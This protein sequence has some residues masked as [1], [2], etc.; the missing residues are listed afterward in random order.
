MSVAITVFF[1]V[2]FELKYLSCV[3]FK[4]LSIISNRSAYSSV[5]VSSLNENIRFKLD[6]PE[7][8]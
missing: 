5:R 2:L 3:I 7:V 4:L 1:N 8:K 6:V